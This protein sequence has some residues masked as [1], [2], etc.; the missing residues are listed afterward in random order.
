MSVAILISATG[1]VATE[2]YFRVD[3]ATHIHCAHTNIAS[4][5]YTLTLINGKIYSIMLS[6]LLIDMFHLACFLV[7]N[8]HTSGTCPCNAF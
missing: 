4:H 7:I 6:E 8:E 2:Y 1:T 3:I 5:Y